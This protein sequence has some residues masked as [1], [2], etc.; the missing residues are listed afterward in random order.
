MLLVAAPAIFTVLAVAVLAWN[1][2]ASAAI[3]AAL[4]WC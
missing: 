3:D 2:L 4:R 1:R